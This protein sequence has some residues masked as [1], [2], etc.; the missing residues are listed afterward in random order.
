MTRR[1]AACVS[2]GTC[3]I[4][5]STVERASGAC[6]ATAAQAHLT[7]APLLREAGKR[8]VDLTPAAVGPYVVP[9]VNVRLLHP[10]IWKRF[11]ARH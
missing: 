6:N 11:L 9:S 1:L 8:V 7:N 4:R 2:R 3:A 10:V 5:S